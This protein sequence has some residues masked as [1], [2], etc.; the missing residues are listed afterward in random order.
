[1][2][3]RTVQRW[4]CSRMEALA[5]SACKNGEALDFRMAEQTVQRWRGT[6]LVYHHAQWPVFISVQ[7]KILPI[8]LNRPCKDGEGL[9]LCIA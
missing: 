4:R 7:S 6:K 9:N 3:K 5:V 2:A 8:Q 1:M